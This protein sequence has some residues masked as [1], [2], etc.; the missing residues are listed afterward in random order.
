MN[1]RNLTL[2]STL[3]KGTDDSDSFIDVDR[4]IAIVIRRA[5][6][7]AL[8]VA[9]TVTLAVV[10]LLFATPQYTSMT[11]ILLDDDI[12]KYAQDP[13]PVAS[14][15]QVDMQIASAVEILK[16]NQLALRVVDAEKLQDNATI[17]D[18]SQSPAEL[19]KSGVKLIVSAL[20]P[21][22]YTHLTLPT[23]LRV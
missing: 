11:Q 7:I 9:A 12:A 17:L 15:Q 21:V 16:S 20:A 8:C 10:Y 18:P 2:H 3:P 22:S 19:I 1:Q 23:I 6:S 13:T 5:G 14:A 4:L